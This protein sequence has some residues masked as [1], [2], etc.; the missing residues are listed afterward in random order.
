MLV[1]RECISF[2]LPKV[3][4]IWTKKEN[5]KHR[6]KKTGRFWAFFQVMD[7]Q[8]GAS[9]KGSLHDACR[10]V[11]TGWWMKPE[12]FMYGGPAGGLEVSP[13]FKGGFQGGWRGKIIGVL[14]FGGGVWGSSLRV[15]NSKYSIVKINTSIS[16]NSDFRHFWDVSGYNWNCK[17]SQ[18]IT[19]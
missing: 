16:A 6:A 10:K 1:F 12:E 13:M 5:K 18:L 2:F 15:W 14:F 17:T 11:S 3:G 8:F 9:K 19:H 7:W 4:G